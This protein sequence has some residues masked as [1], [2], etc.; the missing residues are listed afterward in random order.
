ME[1]KHAVCLNPKY[2]DSHSVTRVYFTSAKFW[3]VLYPN[4]QKIPTIWYNSS[5]NFYTYILYIIL[6]YNFYTLALIIQTSIIAKRV[7]DTCISRFG[8]ACRSCSTLHYQ[9]R[10]VFY[11]S[12]NHWKVF[13][14]ILLTHL[15][16][17]THQPPRLILSGIIVPWNLLH[18]LFGH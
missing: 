1:T 8:D 14:Q 5:F 4:W 2:T 6:L 17:N 10:E 9:Q 16:E 7:I 11:F 18:S 13:K 3:S 12:T 15:N